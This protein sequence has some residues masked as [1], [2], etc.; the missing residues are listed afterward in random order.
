[1]FDTVWTIKQIFGILLVITG[2][3][4]AVKY[5]LQALKIS[6]QKT[7]KTMSRKF[8]LMAIGNDL[9]KIVYSILIL[10]I[11]IFLSSIL[12]I[13][14]MFHLWWNVYLYYPY[15]RRNELYFKRPNIFIF[16]LNGMIPNKYRPHL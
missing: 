10:D 14:C 3:F 15:R 1:M 11:Y 8:V 16:T 2:I 5:S 13:V 12:A 6:K 7:A 9:V 4:D